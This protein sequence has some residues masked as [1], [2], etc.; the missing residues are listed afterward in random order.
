MCGQQNAGRKGV[1]GRA[2][3]GDVVELPAAHIHGNVACVEQLHIF[4]I[5][6][7]D[8][9][10]VPVHVFGRGQEFVEAH[11]LP[12]RVGGG[13]WGERRRGAAGWGECGGRGWRG[14]GRLIGS[15]RRRRVGVGPNRAAINDFAVR[16]VHIGIG[17]P[18]VFHLDA[19][20]GQQAYLLAAGVIERNAGLAAEEDG[21][22]AR[23]QEASGR[24]G[25]R[26]G[27]A[28]RQVVELPAFQVDHGRARVVQFD[29]FIVLVGR[30]VAVPV[31]GEWRG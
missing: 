15:A 22:L 3:V 8:A 5:F 7:Q 24:D 2:A 21:K 25:V 9:I 18:V 11:A 31:N 17:E 23:P 12:G 16:P 30:A 10:A 20:R 19:A 28:V 14:G 1:R 4:I 13:R 29:P 6:I 26:G 27:A